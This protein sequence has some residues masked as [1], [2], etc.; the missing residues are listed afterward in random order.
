M[1]QI[2]KQIQTLNI[3]AELVIRADQT[4]KEMN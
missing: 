1:S 4:R 2:D 3:A